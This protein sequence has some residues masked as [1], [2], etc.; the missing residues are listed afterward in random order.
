MKVVIF[1]GGL[2]TRLSEETH[3]IP[4]PMVKIGER[5]ILWHIM[6]IYSAYGFNDFVICLGYKGY[7][8]KEYFANYYLHESNLTV[9]LSSNRID[10]YDNKAEDWKV[11]L[12]DTGEE[13]MTGERLRLVRNHLNGEPF[14]LTYGDGVANVNLTDLVKF[15]RNKRNILTVTAVENPGRFGSLDIDQ[16]D[17]IT[18]FREKPINSGAWINGG[19]FVCEN[20]VFD[21]IETN[22]GPFERKPLEKIAASG[23]F[24]AFKHNGFWQ[25][26]DTMRDKIR[27][28]VLWKNQEHP[29]KVW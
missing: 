21:F 5:P 15:H 29:W 25:P 8:I 26:M 3:S 6:K 13:S 9:D 23:R 2:G 20:E 10:Y 18:S 4:K 24:G 12:I 14:L 27:L 1:A 28:N 17:R 19:F 16:E 7:V 22:E 11:S